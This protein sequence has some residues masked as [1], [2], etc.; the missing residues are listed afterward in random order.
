MRMVSI[1][2]T[3]IKDTLKKGTEYDWDPNEIQALIESAKQFYGNKNPSVRV[4]KITKKE[5]EEMA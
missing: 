5:L 4:S 1:S 3:S 2:E